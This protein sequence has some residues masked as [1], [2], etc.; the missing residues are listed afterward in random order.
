MISLKQKLERN[1]AMT[2]RVTEQERD[3]IHKA[4]KASGIINMRAYLLKMAANGLIVSIDLNSVHEMNRLLG[5]ATNNINQIAKIANETGSIY[6]ADM[7]EIKFHQE[8][9]WVQQKAILRSLVVIM[10]VLQK[11]VPKKVAD[12]L[13]RNYPVAQ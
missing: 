9:I 10:E 3:L 2:F 13:K 5:N 8:E 7:D 11:G 1:I 4:Q 6:I 12:A